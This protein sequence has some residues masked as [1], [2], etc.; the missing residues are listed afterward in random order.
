MTLRVKNNPCCRILGHSSKCSISFKGV[1]KADCQQ[2]GICGRETDSVTAMYASGS[3]A[4]RQPARGHTQGN[5]I[6]SAKS[7]PLPAPVPA[8]LPAGLCACKVA[9]LLCVTT[10]R[11]ASPHQPCLPAAWL[12]VWLQLICKC[13]CTSMSCDFMPLDI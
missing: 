11:L 7:C 12:L 8:A 13:C 6:N 5:A 3:G 10:S 1:S 4:E 2:P 9:S